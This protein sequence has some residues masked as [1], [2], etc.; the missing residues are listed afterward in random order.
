[1][2]GQYQTRV[3]RYLGVMLACAAYGLAVAFWGAAAT[4]TALMVLTWL[5][6]YWLPQPSG[7]TIPAQYR[8]SRSTR[9]GP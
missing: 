5:C 2:Q 6:Y 9:V 8:A 7:T 1:M 4:E 3:G